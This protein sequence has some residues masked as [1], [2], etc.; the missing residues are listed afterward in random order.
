MLANVFIYTV[1]NTSTFGWSSGEVAM[2]GLVTLV[3]IAGLVYGVI[4]VFGL[5]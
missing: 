5:T 4:S 1:K 3:A 2:W